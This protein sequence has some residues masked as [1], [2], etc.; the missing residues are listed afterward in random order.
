M[1][2]VLMLG[3]GAC[4]TGELPDDEDVGTVD[5]AATI[6]PFRLASVAF[7]GDV[8]IPTATAPGSLVV[9][10]AETFS[11]REV[12]SNVNQALIHNDS[13]Q[14]LQATSPNPGA[15]MILTTC[16][17]L[18]GLQGWS[19]RKK[20]NGTVRFQNLATALYLTAQGPNKAMIMKPLDGLPDQDF[21]RQF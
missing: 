20:P 16:D 4:A 3:L 15:S 10:R 8:M 6:P 19:L 5:Q 14:C 18:N 11:T 17:F 12:W 21:S 2:A 13:F 7:P 1:C 9:L